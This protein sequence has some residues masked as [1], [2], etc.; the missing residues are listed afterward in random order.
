MADNFQ[1]I[2]IGRFG[3][4]D[5]RSDP[6]EGTPGNVHAINCQDIAFDRDGRIRQRPGTSKLTSTATGVA[7]DNL[8]TFRQTGIGVPHV[9]TVD[10]VS[11]QLTSFNSVTGAAVHSFTPTGPALPS[12]LFGGAMIGIPTATQVM[13]LTTDGADFLTKYD[14]TTFTNTAIG[15]GAHHV[16]VQYP[17]NRLVLANSG[18]T[19][20]NSR[21]VFS[22]AN[23]PESFDLAN[24]YVDLLPGDGEQIVGMANYRN[25]LFV[26]KQ[27]AFWR[28][29]GNSTDATGGTVFN[30]QMTRHNLNTPGRYAGRVT[31]AGEEGVY[32]L[33]ADGVYLTTGGTPTKISAPLDPIFELAGK[34]EYFAAFSAGQPGT[35]ELFYAGGQLYLN[36]WN[37]TP[38]AG[39]G[40]VFV[41]DPSTNQWSFNLMYAGRGTQIR[42]ISSVVRTSTLKDTPYFCATTGYGTGTTRTLIGYQDSTSIYDVDHSVS[43]QLVPTYRTNFMD[44]GEPA[45]MKRVREVMLEGSLSAA[46]IGMST[47]NQILVGATGT[48][49]TTIYGSGS[50]PV[51]PDVNIG[52]ARWRRAMRG[53]NFSLNITGTSMLV[54]RAVLHADAPRPA[55]VRLLT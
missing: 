22:A 19:T 40:Q 39:G 28:F 3:G 35:P 50:S 32:F 12:T 11:G 23:N 48:A 26:F 13:Y 37:A 47:D 14:G 7:W 54:N 21:V 1:A 5:L 29:F 10:T 33:G 42:G 18:V 53:S 25:D 2:E 31:A 52:Q 8:L 51:W 27:S 34:A 45:S 15:G 36:W 44:L 24:D 30:N 55:G 49:T 46:S 16:A 41:F 17:D 4:L 9:I 20:T 43:V 6:E 38:L